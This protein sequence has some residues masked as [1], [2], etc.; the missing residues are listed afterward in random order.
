MTDQVEQ[1]VHLNGIHGRKGSYLLSLSEREILEAALKQTIPENFKELE[2]RY[3]RKQI[4]EESG[5]FEIAF[6]RDPN[7][8][9]QAGWGIIFPGTLTA[10]VRDGLV[11]ALH[12]LLALRK[13][14]ANWDAE[15]LYKEY[16]TPEEGA[17]KG[18]SALNW[19]KRHGA[20]P[21]T[22]NPKIIPYYLLLVGSPQEIPLGF[23]YELDA[24]YLV[25]RLYFGKQ[26]ANGAETY[27]LDA[28][29]RYAERVVAAEQ[30]QLKLPRRAVFFGP[31]HE[32]D[33][34]TQQSSADLIVPLYN[35]LS[36][37]YTEQGWQI[38]HVNTGDSTRSRLLELLGEKDA[39]ALLFTASHGVGFDVGDP[40]QEKLQG[41]L[42]CQDFSQV[43]M[44]MERDYYVAG[45]DIL[46]DFSLHGLISFHFA[47]F[48]A[49]TP[50]KDNFYHRTGNVP[51][52]IAKRDFL[53]ALPSRLLSHPRGGALAVCGHVDRAWTYTFKWGKQAKQ[54]TETFRST[55]ARMLSGADRGPGL[56]RYQY[57]LRPDRG[58]PAAAAR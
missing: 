21:G 48:G 8:L 6:G 53:A 26:L 55:L 20:T 22:V 35:E 44:A 5:S 1:K 23:Q 46:D 40:E 25:G 37:N 41:A 18:E 43:G 51:E 16:I 32:G 11:E 19:M 38:E 47:C 33:S 50:Y 24:T 30:G 17:G 56:R 7:K 34:A 36:Q 2:A 13:E 12:P 3:T 49:G 15:E 42:L 58:Q 9:S 52:Q 4:E 10:P 54:Q 27:D 45:E 31:A 39:P 14:Q 28:Y 29:A 57:A